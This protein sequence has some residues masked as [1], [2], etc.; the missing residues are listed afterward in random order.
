MTSQEWR[1]RA[2]QYRTRRRTR[3]HWSARATRLVRGTGTSTTV[4]KKGRNWRRR[5]RQ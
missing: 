2:Q 1:S 4:V 5:R 3:T